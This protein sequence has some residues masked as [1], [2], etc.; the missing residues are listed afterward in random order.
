MSMI[1]DVKEC[2]INR[3]RVVVHIRPFKLLKTLNGSCFM[4]AKKTSLLILAGGST[5]SSTSGN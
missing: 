4:L 5:T 2:A 1:L 3:S